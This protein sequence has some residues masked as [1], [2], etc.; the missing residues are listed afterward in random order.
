MVRKALYVGTLIAAALA[1]T[2]D[3]GAAVTVSFDSLAYNSSSN[4]LTNAALQTYMTNTWTAGGGTGTI[5]LSGAGYLS[6]NQYTGDGHVI[7][8]GSST[9]TVVPLTLGSTNVVGGVITQHS[10]STTAPDN[11]IVNNPS[12]NTTIQIHFSDAIL[13]VKFEYEIFPD[14]NCPT[15]G[16]TGCANT[17]SPNWPDFNFYVDGTAAGNLKFTTD[18]VTPSSGNDNSNSSLSERAPQY[19]SGQVSYTFANGAHDL[20]FVDWPARIGI[21]NVIVDCCKRPPQETPEPGSLALIGLALAGLAAV[22]RR[23]A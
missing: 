12:T 10:L 9:S 16:A 4:P 20:Y 13:G 1:G 6:N 21:D 3:A 23:R 19:L 18:G 7:G 17:S 2:T 15:G 11:Y 5:T 14:G 8:P 22:R